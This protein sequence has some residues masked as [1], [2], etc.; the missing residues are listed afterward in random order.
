[1]ANNV[2][3]IEIDETNQLLKIWYKTMLFENK[4]VVLN[5][6]SGNFEC[7]YQKQKQPKSIF[8]RLFLTSNSNSF[9]FLYDNKVILSIRDSSGWAT[10]QMDDIALTLAKINN[11]CIILK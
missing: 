11:K 4:K 8:F 7:W 6:D 9:V 5:I 3:Q 2:S 10:Q 1:M